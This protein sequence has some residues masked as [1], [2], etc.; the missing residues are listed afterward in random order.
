MSVDVR[1]TKLALRNDIAMDCQQVRPAIELD[2]GHAFF[3]YKF[4]NVFG[5]MGIFT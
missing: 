2:P 1:S 3:F 4:E 5:L